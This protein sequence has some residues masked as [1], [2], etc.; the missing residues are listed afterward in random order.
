ME[1]SRLHWS[2]SSQFCCQ[3]SRVPPS[4]RLHLVQ[5]RHRNQTTP[6]LTSWHRWAFYHQTS[7][8]L[9]STKPSPFHSQEDSKGTRWAE[10][11]TEA[12]IK[13][14]DKLSIGEKLKTLRRILLQSTNLYP[15]HFPDDVVKTE[16]RR[17]N[18]KCHALRCWWIFD[19]GIRRHGGRARSWDCIPQ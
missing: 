5:C 7:R 9:C 15:I 14:F 8:S 17:P 13:G 4:I 2:Q 18:K 11:A 12:E 1:V 3:V 19:K 10:R 16:I 6:Y